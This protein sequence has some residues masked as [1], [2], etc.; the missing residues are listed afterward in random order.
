VMVRNTISVTAQGIDL[1]YIFVVVVHDVI[2]ASATDSTA[3]FATRQASLLALD[4]LEG[5]AQFLTR[6]CDCRTRSQT[7]K[8]HKKASDQILSSLDEEEGICN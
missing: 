4:A 2:L 6:T 8:T 5:D 3:T 7:K 1:T